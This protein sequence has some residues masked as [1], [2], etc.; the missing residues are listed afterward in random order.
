MAQRI[1]PSEVKRA[2]RMAQRK[3][4]VTRLQLAEVLNVKPDRAKGILL[5]AQRESDVSWT[6][7]PLGEGKQ[8]RTLVYRV[9]G[10]KKTA[11]K[12][13]ADSAA[14]RSKKKSSSRKR[15]K[16]KTKKSARRTAKR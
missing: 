15:A 12:K 16:K 10:R 9:E 11:A 2:T 4:G 14:R 1:Q 13:K 5:Q 7:K 6:V 3:C 8:N